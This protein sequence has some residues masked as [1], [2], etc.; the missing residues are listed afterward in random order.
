MLQFSVLSL[1]DDLMTFIEELG[2]KAPTA[3]KSLLVGV[4]S[5]EGLPINYIGFSEDV[6]GHLSYIRRDR[7]DKFTIHT[8]WDSGIRM[9][10]KPGKVLRALFPELSDRDIELAG[11]AL[12]A[13]ARKMS[14]EFEVVD[15]REIVHFYY[16]DNNE[17]GSGTLND[18]CMNGYEQQ[19]L[20]EYYA[21]ADNVKL[22][23]LR[24]KEGHRDICG[25]ALVWSTEC[26]NTVMDRI[27]GNDSTIEA[28]KQ[29][30]KKRGWYY[31]AKQ[32]YA[33]FTNF[34]TP[35]GE[36]KHLLFKVRTG[37]FS[38][39]YMPYMDTFFFSY[40]DAKALANHPDAYNEDCRL[41]RNTDGG[42]YLNENWILCEEN[43]VT[44][45]GEQINWR[46]RQYHQDGC[47]YVGG[48]GMVPRSVFSSEFFMCALR[49]SRYH[50][51]D[52]SV[53]RYDNVEYTVATANVTRFCA[54][55]DINSFEIR[56]YLGDDWTSKSVADIEE[57]EEANSLP[58]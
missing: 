6:P 17:S 54:V 58:F 10:G 28:F 34:I 43:R 2:G 9:R 29:E 15:G 8:I 37:E 3:L 20:V 36:E 19:E 31:R 30:A 32:S 35:E 7:S 18:S 50:E 53:I 57:Q 48:Y 16:E 38:R 12:K 25:R 1:S 13:R 22:L 46:G 55:K 5:V 44:E 45:D 52:L 23:I 49:H 56:P 42:T 51:N 40:E 41:C 26:G 27:Y 21:D 4:M 33:D 47:V 39:H 11:N 24:N 14:Y